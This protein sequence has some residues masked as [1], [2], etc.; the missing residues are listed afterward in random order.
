MNAPRPQ[1]IPILLLIRSAY[2][3]LWQQRD[4]ALRLGFIP[5]LICF[6]GL[7]YSEE[8]VQTASQQAAGAGSIEQALAGYSGMALVSVAI[9]FLSTMLLMANW[10]RFTL[11]GPMGA[12]G[13]GLNIG[14]PHL[15]FAV[16]MVVLAF[17]SGIFFLA[18]SMPLLFLPELL[19][20]V[21]VLVAFIVGLI[22][23]VRLMLYCVA[24]AIGQP[25]SLQDAWRASRG[26]G[27]A[28]TASLVL[29]QVPLWF[30]LVI[31]STVLQLIGFAAVA[32][33]AMLFILAVF[34]SMSA[35]LQAIVLATTFRQ[36]VGIRA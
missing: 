23:F 35:I 22:V 21:G 13:V 5:T 7:L 28:M 8:I 14:R 16:A 3:V 2:Q 26:T 34:Q 11:L 1:T 17:A 27:I 6:G 24:Q 31:V 9:M 18:L 33:L 4:D 29:V 32:P 36:L 15:M 12:V 25:I 10:I 30:L 19:K 20:N